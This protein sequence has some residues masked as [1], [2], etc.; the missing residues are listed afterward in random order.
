MI[1]I[2]DC[3]MGNVGS[4]TNMIRK[5]GGQ[6]KVSS[7]PS[8]IRCAQKLILPGV[9]S[10][11]HGMTNL[12]KNGLIDVL[13]DVV[14]E[15]KTPILGICLG[16]QLL[17]RKSEEGS[18]PGLGWIQADTVR[19]QFPHI[20]EERKLTV[21]HMG[22]SELTLNGGSRLFAN[23]N[24]EARFYFVHSYHVVC[25]RSEDVSSTTV[26]GYDFTAS[27]EHN[28]IFGVQFHP[29]KSHKFGMKLLRNFLEL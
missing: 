20:P 14:L 23:W 21:P 13:H 7:D 17:S 24:D 26:Y 27:L 2:I 10:F 15:K 3:G 12:N 11:D 9:G 8:E 29:E 1:V 19:F 28:N 18:L 25:D 16:M 5:I 22:W 6:A 4:I